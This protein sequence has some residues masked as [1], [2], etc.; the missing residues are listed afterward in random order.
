VGGIARRLNT[1]CDTFAADANQFHRS[2]PRASAVP[3]RPGMV[4]K[5]LV[6]QRSQLAELREVNVVNTT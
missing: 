4:S 2:G 5:P 6:E 3:P 1:A